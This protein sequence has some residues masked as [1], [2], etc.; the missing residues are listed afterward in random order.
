MYVRERMPAAHGAV[1]TMVSSV[2]VPTRNTVRE[3]RGTVYSEECIVNS[4][5]SEE[6]PQP[7]S[8]GK[9]GIPW[10]LIDVLKNGTRRH[11]RSH[12]FLASL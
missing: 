10:S 3:N 12:E 1:T 2:L 7:L 5:H 9:I 11:G 4:E 8:L 6:C